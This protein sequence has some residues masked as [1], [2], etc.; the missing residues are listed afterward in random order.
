M[1]AIQ[2]GRKRLSEIVWAIIDEKVYDYPYEYIE[3]IIAD[4]Q[5]HRAKADYNTGSVSYDDAVDLYKIVTFFNPKV[6]AEVGTFIGVS[7]RTMRLAAPDAQIYTCDMSNDIDLDLT[8][9]TQYP[10]KPSHEMFEDMEKKE[11]KADLVYL[12][13][14]LSEKDIP[15]LLNVITPDTVFVLDDFEGVEKGVANAM[16]LEGR[17]LSFWK[18]TGFLM[19]YPR[20]GHKTAIVIPMTLLQFVR[21]EAV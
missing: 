10:K 14:R 17:R 8:G 7:T 16:T 11:V 13:G 21:Q 4:Q 15:R 18:R 5:T 6:I 3:K 12:D 2:I 1:N 19:V 9:V 20:E